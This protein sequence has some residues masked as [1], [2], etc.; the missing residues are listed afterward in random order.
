M[1]IIHILTTILATVLFITFIL[2]LNHPAVAFIVLINYVSLI[3][4]IVLISRKVES[5]EEAAKQ[6]H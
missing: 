2:L 6:V 4:I 1:R 5:L 3:G